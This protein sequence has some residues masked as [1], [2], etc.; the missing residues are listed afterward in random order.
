MQLRGREL[1][2]E[3]AGQLRDVRERVRACDLTE[4]TR[5]RRRT[6]NSGSPLDPD[7]LCYGSAAL[8]QLEPCYPDDH[9]Q[10]AARPPTQASGYCFHRPE[11][12]PNPAP[13]K[14]PGYPAPCPSP[15]A[16][17]FV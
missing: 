14:T 11:T 17:D 8:G 4:G 1:A 10:V 15:F 16:S 13:C 12:V 2:G 6:P 3:L 7:A 5:C 9:L